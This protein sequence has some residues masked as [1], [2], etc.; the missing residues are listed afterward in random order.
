MQKLDL[1]S[2]KVTDAALA[3]LKEM[4][5]LQKLALGATRVSDAGLTQL[6]GM[7]G[8][9]ELDLAYTIVTNDGLA[10]LTEMTGLQTLDLSSTKV[11]DARFRLSCGD[12]RLAGALSQEPQGDGRRLGLPEGSAEPAGALPCGNRE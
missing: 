8:L 11:S 5:A 12:D 10:Q 9:R 3:N 4:T 2:T 1:S 6:K 7:K